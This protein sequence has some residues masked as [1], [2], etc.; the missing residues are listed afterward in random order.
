MDKQKVVMMV[1]MMV[2]MMVV[3]QAVTKVEWK[4]EKMEYYSEMLKVV[5]MAEQKVVSKVD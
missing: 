4:V 3:N 2:E 1:A 5:M